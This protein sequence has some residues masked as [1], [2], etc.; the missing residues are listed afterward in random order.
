MVAVD[1]VRIGGASD[2]GY[3]VPDILD[4]TSHCFSPGVSDTAD[5]EHHL[6]L[7]H[8]IKSFLADASV[9]GPP[10]TNENFSFIKK[11]LGSRTENDFITLSD[12]MNAELEGGEKGIILRMDIEGGEYE[13]LTT[14]SDETLRRFSIMVI[15]FHSLHLMAD[16]KFSKMFTAIFEKIFQSFLVCHVHPNNCCGIAS[17]FGIEVPR[18]IEVT[19]LRNDLAEILDKQTKIQL[20]HELDRKNVPTKEDLI[21]PAIWWQH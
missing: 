1:L 15:E 4:S 11:F 14:E 20:P 16:L 18:V 13:V 5:F 8:G 7:A 12:W 6:S 3:L 9:A 17:I 10:I 21:M 2:G 19:F